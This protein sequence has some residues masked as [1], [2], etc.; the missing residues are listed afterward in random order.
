M[1][2]IGLSS[3]VSAANTLPPEGKLA[4]VEGDV[5]ACATSS[6]GGRLVSWVKDQASAGAQK[7]T[8]QSAFRLALNNQYGENLATEPIHRPA[9]LVGRRMAGTMA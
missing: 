1:T 7:G 8:D 9:G 5:K 2:V 4:V 6:L 3:F